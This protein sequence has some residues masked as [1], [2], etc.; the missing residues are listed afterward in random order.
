VLGGG[1]RPAD[2]VEGARRADAELPVRE[3]AFEPDGEARRGSAAILDD[4]RVDG[5]GDVGVA[6]VWRADGAAHDEGAEGAREGGE[7]PHG[8]LPRHLPRGELEPAA[9]GL[10]HGTQQRGRRPVEEVRAAGELDRCARAAVQ[11]ADG[12]H[13]AVRGVDAGERQP[14]VAG[15]LPGE[16]RRWKGRHESTEKCRSGASGSC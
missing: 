7:P 4:D 3:L 11:H 5:A 15:D 16:R 10:D 8:A 6:A 14:V 9:V 13:G 1:D 2:V 12:V